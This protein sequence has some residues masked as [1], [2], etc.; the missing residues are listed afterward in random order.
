VIP[1]PG[2]HGQY[3]PHLHLIA[4]SGGWA[5]QAQPWL[6]LDEGPYALL[7]Q[8]WQRPLLMRLPQTGKTPESRRVVDICYTRSR[9]GFVTNGQKGE[10]PARE[11]S[12][13][14]YRA[15]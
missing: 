3:Q 12:L 14:R 8:K 6:P 9:E 5:R 7:R 1:S 15:R 4:T 10:V 13:A 11:Q 2:R